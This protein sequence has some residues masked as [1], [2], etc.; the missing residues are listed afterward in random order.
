MGIFAAKKEIGPGTVLH[1]KHDLLFNQIDGEVVMLSLENSEYYGMDKVGSRI[2]ELLEHPLTLKDL[3][4]KLMDEYTVSEEQCTR[5]T[6]AFINKL[7][8]KA[9][10]AC[11]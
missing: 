6:L 5:E 9:L 4:G 1:R 11:E 10:I 3:V 2:W 8:D 7:K